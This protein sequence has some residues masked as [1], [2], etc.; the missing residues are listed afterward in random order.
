[1]TR[2][3]CRQEIILNEDEHTQLK[4]LVRKHTIEQNIS[5]R[6]QIVL[7]CAE[8]LSD[9]AVGRK[10]NICARTVGLWRKRFLCSGFDGLCDAPRSGA[11]RSIDDEDVEKIIKMTLESKPK[12]A[13]HWST[14]SMAKQSG[15]SQTAISRI[16]RAFGLKPHKIETFKISNDPNFL[17]KVR[18][19]VG[20]YLSPPQN[21]VVFCIDENSQIQALDRTQ[22]LLPMRPGQAERRTH[23]YKRYGTTTLFAALNTLTGQLVGQCYPRHRSEEFEKFLCTID[24][25]VPKGLDIHIILDNYGT[26]KTKTIQQ[27]LLKRPRV[28]FH[29]IPTSSSWLNMIERW[30]AE[31]TN[32]QIKR[33]IHR[34]V[35]E[36]EKAINSFIVV[37]NENPKPFVWVKTAEQIIESVGRFCERISNSGH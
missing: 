23:D 13:T 24:K 29:F 22:P 30:F 36:L 35:K 14:R 7:L 15:M 34:S 17:D 16:W 1:M 2:G 33:G 27:W 8:G 37:T 3:P 18:D 11:P 9:K 31:L 21:A 10:L 4:K 6:A 20:L 26:H 5:R 32:K 28:H 12:D 25:N 19:V